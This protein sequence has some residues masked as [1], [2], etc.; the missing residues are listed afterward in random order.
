[1]AGTLASSQMNS[2]PTLDNSYGALLLGTCISL[3]LY[4]VS[5]HQ[6]YRYFRLY[7]TDT[8]SIRTLVIVL[9]ILETLLSAFLAH[10]CYHTLV[11]NYFKPLTLL[12]S[13]WSLKVAPMIVALITCEAQVRPLFPYSVCFCREYLKVVQSNFYS[14]MLRFINAQLGLYSNH[15][16]GLAIAAVALTFRY[17]ILADLPSSADWLYP[18]SVF[19]ATVADLL[20]ASVIFAGLQRS[21]ANCGIFNAI[22]FILAVRFPRTLVWAAFNC[23]SARLYANTLLSVLNSRKF[24]VSREIKVFGPDPTSHG[25]FART[26]RF[27]AVEQWGAPQLP[28]NTPAIIHITVS[29]ETEGDGARDVMQKATIQ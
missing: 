18:A 20:L 21:H 5:L 1:M 28:D 4:G 19:S 15:G 12:E 26:D 23:V 9:M 16:S 13:V 14:D 2:F 3:I 7:S 22:P 17:Q 10:T 24:M 11:T 29:A 25:I 6:L 27:A 8:P